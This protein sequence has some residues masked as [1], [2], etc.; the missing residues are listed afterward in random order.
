MTQLFG[1]DPDRFADPVHRRFLVDHRRALLDFYQPEVCLSGGG[2]AWIGADGRAMPEMGAQL[3]IGARMIHVFSLA[4]LEGR[5]GARDVVEHGLGFYLDGPG[6]DARFDGWFPVVGG[7]HPQ[8][9]KELYGTAQLLLAASSATQAGFERGPALLA[10]CAELIDRHYWREE[11]GSCVEGYD[12]SFSQLDDYRGQN[13]NMHLTEAYLAAYEATGDRVYLDRAASIAHRIAA[14]AAE[15]GEGG[16]RLP[17]HFTADWAPRLDYNAGDPR[18]PFR[19][20]GSQPG[21]W[22]EWAKLLVQLRGLGFEERWL[23]P[24]AAALFDGAI[25][26]AWADGG[27]FVYTVDWDGR[28]VV[29]ERFFWEVAEAMGAARFLWLATGEQ[30]YQDWYDTFWRF[31]DAHL[32]DH[33]LGGWHSE[34]N[35]RNEP[36]ALTWDG[37]PDLYHV[38]QATLYA[39]VP[40]DRGFA[41]WLRAAGSTALA[42]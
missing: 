39:V 25:R 5:A 42:D 9:R 8:D 32:V 34:L 17:E 29:E 28:P 15:G 31:A 41:A 24:A 2:Y 38:Y 40:V 36:V 33:E 6:R 21:H 18:H 26:D 4:S 11:D 12:R 19:P 16:W 20:Y 13:A 7:D 22:L 37:K 10:A 27:G 23:L 1:D 35:V 14:R 30:R 3:F